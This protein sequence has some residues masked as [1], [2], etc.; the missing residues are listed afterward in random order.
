MENGICIVVRSSQDN[1]VVHEIIAA[2]FTDDSWC[3]HRITRSQELANLFC[4][5]EVSTVVGSFIK[6]STRT[7]T[8]DAE[9][10]D[11]KKTVYISVH[12]LQFLILLIKNLNA[13]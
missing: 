13:R 6:R 2:E 12:I 4:G 3:S 11:D 9:Q 10:A 5:I 1:V 8:Y 7:Y